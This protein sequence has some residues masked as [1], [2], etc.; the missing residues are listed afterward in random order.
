VGI[1]RRGQ[2][3]ARAISKISQF[4]ALTL[5]AIGLSVVIVFH[6]QFGSP[7]SQ[8]MAG[9]S[10]ADIRDWERFQ[11]LPLGIRILILPYLGTVMALVLMVIRK[12]RAL[13][14]NFKN[15]VVF[16]Q[17]NVRVIREISKLVIALSIL[18][19]SAGALLTGVI[20]LL[21]CEI[22]KAGVSLQE[23]H[24]LTV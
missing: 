3:V 22:V 11:S 7:F 13:F 24:D 6:A 14:L 4:E 10:P 18:T 2:T 20:L 8:G 21:L 15:E 17:G 9:S 1:F 23:E 12:A 19:F 5:A 16:N